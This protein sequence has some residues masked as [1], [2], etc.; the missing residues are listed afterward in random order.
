MRKRAHKSEKIQLGPEQRRFLKI[1]VLRA[2]GEFITK[3]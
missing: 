3:Q 2:I 1:I